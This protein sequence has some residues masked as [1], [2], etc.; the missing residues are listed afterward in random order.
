VD[1]KKTP[2]ILSNSHHHFA[3]FPKNSIS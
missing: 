1:T 3:Y 2:K